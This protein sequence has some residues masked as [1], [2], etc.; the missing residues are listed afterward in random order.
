MRSKFNAFLGEGLPLFSLPSDLAAQLMS[1]PPQDEPEKATFPML[2]EPVM[3]DEDS[4]PRRLIGR[5]C[6]NLMS[7]RHPLCMEAASN[8]RRCIFEM[9]GFSLVLMDEISFYRILLILKWLTT[10]EGS[11]QARADTGS[12]RDGQTARQPMQAI[13]ISG[14]GEHKVVDLISHQSFEEVVSRVKAIRCS[15]ENAVPEHTCTAD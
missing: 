7:E 13:S 9:E 12:A 15:I 11:L 4:V 14:E 3:I 6:V 1:Y 2:F 8:V 10:A 5:I